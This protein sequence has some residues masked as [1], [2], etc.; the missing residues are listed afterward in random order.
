MEATVDYIGDASVSAQVSV[1]NQV[2]NGVDAISIPLLTQRAFRRTEEGNRCWYR[3]YHLGLR[4]QPRRDRTLMV[5]GHPRALVR[6]LLDMGK[7]GL[8][9]RGSDPEKDDPRSGTTRQIRCRPE[10]RQVAAQKIIMRSI[11]WKNVL[12]ELYP[13][14]TQSRQSPL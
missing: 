14:R 5:S 8:K 9:E 6:C 4:R 12:R 1:I 10:P 7:V 13:T 3:S 2:A 11:L